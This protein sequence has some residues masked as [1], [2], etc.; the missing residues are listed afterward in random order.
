M[1]QLGRI[2][3]YSRTLCTIIFI[4]CFVWT[5]KSRVS[6]GDQ[7]QMVQS[8]PYHDETNQI[9]D[10]SQVLIRNR[11][12][13]RTLKRVCGKL[14]EGFYKHSG[15]YKPEYTRK[16]VVAD[17]YHRMVFCPI[18]KVSSSSWLRFFAT[19]A[20]EERAD[21]DVWLTTHPGNWSV[22][23]NSPRQRGLN[24]TG[25]KK[26]SL[27]DSS[28]IY[29]HFTFLA[30]RHPLQRL[31]SAY[32]YR[33]VDRHINKTFEDFLRGAARYVHTDTHYMPF[34]NTCDPCAIDF[35]VIVQMETVQEDLQM[36]CS[37]LNASYMLNKFPHQKPGS[38]KAGAE[39]YKGMY[40]DIS[41]QVL[42][43]VFA[44]FKPDADMFGYSFEGYGNL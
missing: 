13:R 39:A 44:K 29:R 41:K 24:Q 42:R 22:F 23:G 12:R 30:V 1:S 43:D 8:S 28:T 20:K 32:M 40:A 10:Q 37:K 16:N 35:D 33:I 9:I 7:S 27:N 38:L 26:I 21:R 4:A 15:Y 3:L 5:Q 36:V 31:V 2:T 11:E 25:L 34:I 17:Q 19:M 6:I 14:Q 18:Q